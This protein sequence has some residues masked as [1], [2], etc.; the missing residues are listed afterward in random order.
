MARVFRIPRKLL[1]LSALTLLGSA[2]DHD[3]GGPLGPL[4]AERKQLDQPR[5]SERYVAP[6][7]L[8]LDWALANALVPA[9]QGSELLARIRIE[10]PEQL[11]LP[12]PP[13][14]VVLVVDTSASMKG[15]AIEGAKQAAIALVDS[16]AEGDS[17]S[18]V[19]FHSRAEV[20]MPATV[21]GE[22]SRAAARAEIETMQAWGTTD[23]AGGLRLALEQLAVAPVSMAE[24]NPAI[25]QPSVATSGGPDPQV[26]ERV[27][28]LGDGVPMTP[29]RSL[30]SP[31]NSPRVE[32]RSPRSATGSNSTRCYWRAWL[33]RPM[34]TFASSSSPMP[35]QHC[36]VTRSCTFS[37]PSL[38][39]C[40]SPW[41]SVRACACSK[42][43]VIRRSGTR[44]SAGWRLRSAASPKVS[45]RS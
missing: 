2:C 37:A 33:S 3:G 36:F 32:P 19:V 42:S 23:L 12:R 16:L 34:A 9:E 44:A 35:S 26:L 10:A 31:N 43:S 4:D 7:D 30:G 21:I 6:V 27:V 13:A 15:D 41:A 5:V 17:F 14:R 18:L 8:E 40:G 20:L 24:P 38:A 28:L 25:G 1:L 39:I 45:A 22:Q 29:A 11:D